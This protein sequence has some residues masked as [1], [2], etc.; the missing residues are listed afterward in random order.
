MGFFSSK[1]IAGILAG[2]VV[3][4]GSAYAFTGEDNL[5]KAK[6]FIG[7]STASLMQ[8]ES[9]E[10]QLIDT[11]TTLQ[12]EA[13]EKINQANA[14]IINLKDQVGT[15]TTERDQLQNTVSGLESDIKGLDTKI[16]KLEGLLSDEQLKNESLTNELARVKAD[17]DA[18]VA[19][20]EAT[21]AALAE[22]EATLIATQSDLET[23]NNDLAI[24]QSDLQTAYGTISTQKTQ[25]IEADKQVAELEAELDEANVE[26]TKANDKAEEVGQAVDEAKATI[27][28]AKPAAALPGAGD[29]TLPEVE[30]V[31]TK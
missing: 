7:E 9:N 4:G 22:T 31:S 1:I 17:R 15:L 19:E 14:N 18:K 30:E 26:I 13:T 8:Y 11:V 5:N 16:S 28:D 29:I 23:A 10:N 24:A 12:Q 27:G 3:V 25:L 20:L 21:K 6:G 2:T